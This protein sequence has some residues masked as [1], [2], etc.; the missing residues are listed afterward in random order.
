MMLKLHIGCGHNKMEGWVNV[1][2]SKELKPDRVA[3][4]EKLPFGTSSVDEIFSQ[5]VLE[6][7]DDCAQALKETWRVLKPGANANIIV[8]YAGIVNAYHPH[9][10]WYFS[11]TSFDPFRR[12]DDQNYYY[13]FWFS[14]VRVRLAFSWAFRW[15]Q[16]FA[17][18][19]PQLY[20]NSGLAWMFPAKELH[21]ELVK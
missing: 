9:H 12:G 20:E 16:P 10:N 21:I 18:K 13:G 5:H 3:R 11:Y 2:V 1:D 6:H 17:N 4:W 15:M 19:F 7:T 8:P 14:E